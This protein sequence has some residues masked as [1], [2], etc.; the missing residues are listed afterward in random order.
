[1][2]A[3]GGDGGLE[4]F[5]LDYRSGSEM[6]GLVTFDRVAGLDSVQRLGPS[7]AAGISRLVREPDGPWKDDPSETT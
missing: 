6:Q 7:F 3:I 5:A 4:T 2:F 1:V